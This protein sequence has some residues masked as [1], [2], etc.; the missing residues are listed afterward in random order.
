MTDSQMKDFK[1]LSIDEQKA[2]AREIYGGRYR[3]CN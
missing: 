3:R 1:D 2:I